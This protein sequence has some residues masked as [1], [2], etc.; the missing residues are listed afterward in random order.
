M[1]ASCPDSYLVEP[2]R[3][4]YRF[5]NRCAY[6]LT[7]PIQP[8]ENYVP[9]VNNQI[10]ELDRRYQ[11][12]VFRKGNVLQYKKNSSNLTKNQRYSQIA[13]GLWTNRTKSWAT[14]G[15]SFTDPNTSS[16]KRVN[17]QTAEINNTNLTPTQSVSCPTFSNPSFYSLPSTS[18]ATNTNQPIIPPVITT[19]PAQSPIIPVVSTGPATTSVIIPDGG[20][21]VCNISENFCTGEIYQ[22]TTTRDCYPSTDSDVPGPFTLLCWNDGLPTYYPRR[23]YTYGSSGNKFPTNSKGIVSA[24]VVP[25]AP[26]NFA[27]VAQSDSSVA[28][29]WTAPAYNGGTTIT[30]YTV[31]VLLGD[32]KI[33]TFTGITSNNKT[34]SG[35]TTGQ[36]Y[37]FTVSAVNQIGTGL[38]ASVSATA[39]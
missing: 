18:T 7:D 27:G 3:E 35:L 31:I 22:I 24:I 6:S 10:S 32:D 28:L 20:N 5:E 30:S 25:Y 11:E 16:L 8:D 2:P 21:L 34:V 37:T 9:F 39:L 23:Q 4:W 1:S 15:V 13:R 38:P 17:Y 12:T 14:Q 29:S 19:T 36:S 33:S 26:L